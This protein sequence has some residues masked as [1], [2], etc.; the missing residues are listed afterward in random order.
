M[1][2]GELKQPDMVED[3]FRMTRLSESSIR[4]TCMPVFESIRSMH[5]GLPMP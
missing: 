3:I 2:R 5:T 1:D 4:S